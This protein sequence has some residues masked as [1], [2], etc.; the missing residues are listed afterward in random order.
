MSKGEYMGDPNGIILSC[1]FVFVEVDDNKKPTR[2]K[3][4][5]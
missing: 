1:E 2:H 5:P 4:A 3:L